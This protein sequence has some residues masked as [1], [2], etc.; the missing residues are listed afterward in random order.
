MGVCG[1]D[2][3]RAAPAHRPEDR[4]RTLHSGRPRLHCRRVQGQDTKYYLEDGSSA[5]QNI[6]VAAHAHG[7]G[8]CRIA[9]DKKMYADEISKEVGAPDG[10]KLVSMISVGYP[11]EQSQK[12]RRTLDQPAW[13]R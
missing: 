8:A 6:L 10:Y 3:P 11:A 4:L 12:A 1:R 2:R 5:T 9:G 13:V 7:L